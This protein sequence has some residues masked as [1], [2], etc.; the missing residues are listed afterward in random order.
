M[1]LLIP[2]FSDQQYQ[3]YFQP[4]MYSQAHMGI[5]Q[6]QVYQEQPDPNNAQMA[7][8]AGYYVQPSPYGY[9]AFPNQQMAV[10]PVS[11]NYLSF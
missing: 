5:H 7:Y 8:N 10:P 4:N 1:A 6:P 2:V 3:Q 9:A 11:W